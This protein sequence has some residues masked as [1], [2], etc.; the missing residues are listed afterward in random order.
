MAPLQ[1]FLIGTDRGLWMSSFD[2]YPC[3]LFEG[4]KQRLTI[5][6]ASHEGNRDE[7][8][9]TTRYTRCSQTSERPYLHD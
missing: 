6:L 2:V 5:L 4:A 3:K 1:E 8:V 9:W 7:I